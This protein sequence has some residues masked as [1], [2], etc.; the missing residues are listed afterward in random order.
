MWMIVRPT[1]NKGQRILLILSLLRNLKKKNLNPEGIA[2]DRGFL[3]L[4]LSRKGLSY[5]LERVWENVLNNEAEAHWKESGRMYFSQK[6][7]L[8]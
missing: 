7:F 3:D 4:S 5:P 1:E 6:L 2:K 8:L